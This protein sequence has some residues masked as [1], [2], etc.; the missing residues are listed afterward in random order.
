[1]RYTLCYSIEYGN[2][3][4]LPDVSGFSE[5]LADVFGVLNSAAAL[6]VVIDW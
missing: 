6:G 3:P 5:N 4:I 1:M 2:P